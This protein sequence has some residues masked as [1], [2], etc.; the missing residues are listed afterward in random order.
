MGTR[1]STTRLGPDDDVDNLLLSSPVLYVIKLLLL[2]TI[3]ADGRLSDLR[4]NPGPPLNIV[5]APEVVYRVI[6]I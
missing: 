4:R 5:S 3:M 1:L 6:L 2:F